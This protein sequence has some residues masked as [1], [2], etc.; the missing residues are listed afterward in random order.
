MR[1][2]ARKLAALSSNDDV[3]VPLCSKLEEWCEVEE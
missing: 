3:G 1:K 2:F